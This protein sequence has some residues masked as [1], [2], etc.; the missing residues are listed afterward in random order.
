MLG[1]RLP[2]SVCAQQDLVLKLG[3]GPQLPAMQLLFDAQL[4]TRQHR[5]AKPQQSAC[6]E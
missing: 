1:A 5:L 4:H 6:V 3:P 2:E